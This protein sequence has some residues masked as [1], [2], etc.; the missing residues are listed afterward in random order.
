MKNN[1]LLT[2]LICMTM[3]FSGVALASCGMNNTGSDSSGSIVS[4]V[5]TTAT[6]KFDVNIEGYETNSVKDK[7]VSIGKRVPIVKAYVTGENPDNLQLYG[8]YTDKA[9]TDL[10]DF[11]ADRVQGDHQPTP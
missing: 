7:T 11:K 8:W 4:E 5:K 2:M 6:V 1:K 10:W 3:L 9:C